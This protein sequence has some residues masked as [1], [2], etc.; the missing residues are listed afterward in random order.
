MFFFRKKKKKGSV[1]KK[2]IPYAYFED[3]NPL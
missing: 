1:E 3:I 2:I